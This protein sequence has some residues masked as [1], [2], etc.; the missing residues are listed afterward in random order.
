MGH[1]VSDYEAPKAR[2]QGL[3]RSKIHSYRARLRKQRQFWHVLSDAMADGSADTFV[4]QETERDGVS[5]QWLFAIRC[6]STTKRD[7]LA[8]TLLKSGIDSMKMYDQVPEM[9]RLYY[10]YRGD[11]IEA[12][13]L[14]HTVLGIPVLTADATTVDFPLATEL[15]KCVS[16]SQKDTKSACS[17]EGRRPRSSFSGECTSHS[18]RLV[19]ISLPSL[20]KHSGWPT[21]RGKCSKSVGQSASS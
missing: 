11:A 18:P 21:T 14:C 3:V 6:S 8:D 9:A 5:D 13:K 4:P 12:E 7:A 10:G 2:L 1:H 17:P 15:F 16:S 20:E 19:E